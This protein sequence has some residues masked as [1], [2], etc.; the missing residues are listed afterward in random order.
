MTQQTADWLIQWGVYAIPLS[1]MINAIMNILGVVPS[2]L[3]TGANVLLWGPIFGG[4]ISWIGEVI[5]ATLAFFL[6]RRGWK[7]F[8]RKQSLD[9]HWMRTL[10]KLSKRRQFQ[11]LFVARL[12][13]MVPSGIINFL[14]ALS[15]VPFLLFLLATFLGKI[16]S[17]GFEVLISYDILHIQENGIR[18]LLLL[19]SLTLAYWI[20]RT[21]KNDT[22][23]PS[24]A[25]TRAD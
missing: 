2:V 25:K 15:G 3:I 6:Y 4:V 24:E 7:Y 16:P 21:T 10:Q 22:K 5:G 23:R 20:W 19:L 13:P 9:W 18:L 12:T 11:S 8:Q 17:I 14:A 1:I